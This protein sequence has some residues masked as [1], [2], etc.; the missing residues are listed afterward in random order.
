MANT[1][2]VTQLQTKV[3]ISKEKL[4][5]IGTNFGLS[6]E[7]Y[8]VLFLLFSELSGW[9]EP[10]NASTP[11]PLNYTKID[12]KTISDTLGYKKKKV[13][14]CIEDLADAGLIEQG[15]NDKVTNGWRFTF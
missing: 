2:N 8:R 15:S 14:K 6:E 7:D 10:L 4:I 3:S 13:K 5:E 1:R 12:P 11:D 9:S